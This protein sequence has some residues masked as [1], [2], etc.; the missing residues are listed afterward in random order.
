MVVCLCR[1]DAV[2]DVTELTPIFSARAND[3]R[4]ARRNVFVIEQ[5]ESPSKS[6]GLCRSFLFFDLSRHFQKTLSNPDMIKQRTQ[7]R[8]G[9]GIH[10]VKA[11]V[12][13]IVFVFRPRNAADT[14]ANIKLDLL[15]CKLHIHKNN[16]TSDKS[17]VLW[18]VTQF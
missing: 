4:D 18:L 15:L 8:K 3:L 2:Y 17:R 11:T 13:F 12:G 7:L 16:A 14:E 9:N 6:F 5:G 1:V 10:H